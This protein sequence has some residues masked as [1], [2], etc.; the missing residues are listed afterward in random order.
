MENAAEDAPGWQ[1]G[2]ECRLGCCGPAK[3]CRPEGG[4]SLGRLGAFGT[5]AAERT[6]N[7]AKSKRGATSRQPLPHL[8]G[9]F[10]APAVCARCHRPRDAPGI[11]P[12][13][14]CNR[15]TLFW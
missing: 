11:R 2:A 5:A 10:P 9:S 13:L 14:V 6:G 15:T 7:A 1:A 12:R 4:M 3:E 8:T